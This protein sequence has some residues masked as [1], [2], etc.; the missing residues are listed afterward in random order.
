VRRLFENAHKM[1]GGMAG[2]AVIAGVED[3]L[4]AA[5]L[6]PGDFYVNV[7]AVQNGEHGLGHAGKKTVH[8]TLDECRHRGGRCHAL[9]VEKQ[10]MRR[11][12]TNLSLF[13]PADARSFAM[14]VD[15]APRLPPAVTDFPR[16][17]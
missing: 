15:P 11:R 14:V 4:T 3:R 17:R 5:G 9:T 13:P 16:P 1:L 8:Q 7:Q 12:P 2:L 6:L 10:A